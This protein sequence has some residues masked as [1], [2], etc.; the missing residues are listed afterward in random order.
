[1]GKFD[2]VM[3]ASDFDDTFFPASHTLP[4]ANR[5]AVAYFPQS[6]ARRTSSKGRTSCLCFRPG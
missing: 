4:E 2:G 5:E 1:M 3:I 6:T